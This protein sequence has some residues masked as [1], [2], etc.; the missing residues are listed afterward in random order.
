MVLPV[1]PLT[2][3]QYHP[4]TDPL[5]VTGCYGITSPQWPCPGTY[6]HRPTVGVPQVTSKGAP[7]FS[8][9]HRRPEET[10]KGN[11]MRTT[12]L[13]QLVATEVSPL[14]FSVLET[15]WKVFGGWGLMVV[16]VIT[17]SR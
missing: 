3:S 6:P 10:N 17:L 13:S 8:F 12:T 11:V 9:G 1:S 4:H 15:Y 16:V 5:S 2:L 14:H 7:A